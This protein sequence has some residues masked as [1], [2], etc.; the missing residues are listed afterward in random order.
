MPLPAAVVGI[1]GRTAP[2]MAEGAA[3]AGGAGPGT[4]TAAAN[5][6]GGAAPVG[7]GGAGIAAGG[8]VE[9]ATVALDAPATGAA[10]DCVVVGRF[11]ESEL[12]C[13]GESVA[14]AAGTGLPAK[15]GETVA[16]CGAGGAAIGGCPP[17]ACAGAAG[18]PLDGGKGPAVAWLSSCAPSGGAGGAGGAPAGVDIAG[19]VANCSASRICWPAPC[20]CSLMVSPTA[21]A[22]GSTRFSSW[23]RISTCVPPF[24][25]GPMILASRT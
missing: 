15:L 16:I 14:G 8:G 20:T 25:A 3:G 2:A 7:E 13:V 1:T 19:A 6:E 23:P 10:P 12:F 17:A 4:A 24:G 22:V 9:D 18:A 5:G 11:T 21:T